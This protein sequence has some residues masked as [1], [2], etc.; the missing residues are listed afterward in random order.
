MLPAGI[1]IILETEQLGEIRRL[2]PLVKEAVVRQQLSSEDA[3]EDED[4]DPED[5]ESDTG[6]DSVIERVPGDNESQDDV[7]DT[8]GPTDIDP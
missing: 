1:E 7:S 3:T 5:T 2:F 6:D 8:D 4:A